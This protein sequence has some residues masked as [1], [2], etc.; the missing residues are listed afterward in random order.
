MAT[1]YFQKRYLKLIA[2]AVKGVIVLST[3][4]TKKLIST[5]KSIVVVQTA[6][7]GDM[8]C[9][10]PIFH[11]I[12]KHLPDIKLIVVGTKGGE[13]ICMPTE[14]IDEYIVFDDKNPN[15]TIQILRKKKIDAG[16]VVVP[17]LDSL[18]L[19]ASARI[20]FIVA[21]KLLNGNNPA[22]TRLYKFLLSFVVIR[23]HTFGTYAAREYLRL[24]EPFD[25]HDEDTTKHLRY[26]D[27]AGKRVD[28]V[29]TQENISLGEYVC[30]APGAGNKVKQWPPERFAKVADYIWNTYH[31]PIAIF[32]SSVDQNEV[33]EMLNALSP[34]TKYLDTCGKFSLD[35]AKALIAKASLLIAADTMAIYIA[36]AFNTSL[37]DIVGPVAPDEQPPK[38]PN[39]I[40]VIPPY[41]Y[42]P[43]LHIMNARIYN[44][45]EARKQVM[46]ITV[47]MVTRAVDS[48]LK[49]TG[50]K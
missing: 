8:V 18:L 43:Q 49:N 46:S 44:E 11:A 15:I 23:P 41:D 32:G 42:V 21:P 13:G 30:I 14:D 12:K 20:P 4:T 5:P 22:N 38:G 16:I 29:L 37:I 10:T 34:N 1:N 24:L 7:L 45:A 47:G 50:N 40:L 26:S 28:I 31:L 2:Q 6:Q 33:V 19:L 39:R 27:L 25:I 36:E 48:L 9:T 35:E 17:S 3:H